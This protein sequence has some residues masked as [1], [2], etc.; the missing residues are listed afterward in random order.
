M[1]FQLLND[2][3]YQHTVP[4]YP[5]LFPYIHV[6]VPGYFLNQTTIWVQYFCCKDT[7]YMYVHC[8][9]RTQ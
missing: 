7:L 2:F 8:V 6:C 4:G 3:P 1:N 9:V 5:V